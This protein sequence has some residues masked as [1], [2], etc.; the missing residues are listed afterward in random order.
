M[1][2]PLANIN[3]AVM[4]LPGIFANINFMD[5]AKNERILWVLFSVACRARVIQFSARNIPKIV[6]SNIDPTLFD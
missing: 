2:Y 3:A 4:D 6:C 5:E 1:L